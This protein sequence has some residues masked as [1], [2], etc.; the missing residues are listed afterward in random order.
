MVTGTNI[1]Y[2]FVY[3]KKKNL[4][5]ITMIYNFIGQPKSGKT[6]L[7]YHLQNILINN[8]NPM[9]FK[10]C[11]VVDEDNLKNIL[12]NK[13]FSEKGIRRNINQIYN[14]AK[15]LDNDSCFDVIIA[16]VSPFLD[17]REKLKKEADVIEIYVHT[18]D[19][20]GKEEHHL[21]YFEAPMRNFIEVDTTNIDEFTTINELLNNIENHGK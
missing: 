1:I 13:D 12:K 8:Y 15:F 18:T 3:L 20:R 5:F 6:T 2:F 10:H 9:L 19:I 16:V 4:K 14:I 7:A 11:I 21:P 17:L